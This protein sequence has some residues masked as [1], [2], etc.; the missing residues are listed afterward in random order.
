MVDG[1]TS[2]TVQIGDAVIDE[3]LLGVS[4][5]RDDQNRGSAK[6]IVDPGRCSLS[7]VDW[8]A[9]IQIRV[10]GEPIFTGVVDNV[11][12]GSSVTIRAVDRS[13]ELS[14]LQMGGLAT[15]RLPVPEVIWSLM[16][17]GGVPEDRMMIEGVDGPTEPFTVTTPLLGV[18]LTGARQ[19][20]NVTVV[21][22]GRVRD[23]ARRL[24][25]SESPPDLIE[26]FESA[27]AWALVTC[28]EA[29]VLD[30]ETTAL[31]RVDVALGWMMLV[32]HYSSPRILDRPLRPYYRAATLARPHRADVVMV[33]GT[34]TGRA[35]LRAPRDW[36]VERDLSVDQH[37]DLTIPSFPS[38]LPDEI[39]EA[40]LSWQRAVQHTDQIGT[41]VALWEAIEFYA[42]STKV[43]ALFDKAE[44]RSIRD[45]L[46][47][48][49]GEQAKRL[50]DAINNLNNAPLMVRLEAALV[51][52]RMPFVSADLE[53]LKRLRAIRNNFAHGRLRMAP[54]R[55]D[56]RQGVAL[57]G[58]MLAHRV[59][60]LALEEESQAIAE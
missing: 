56:V 46:P 31:R 43:D 14:E 60:K 7:G 40:V 30:A 48:L 44:L 36:A 38:E 18:R 26:R 8:R 27:S 25:G 50:T 37:A 13:Q 57:V 55:Q 51:A 12:V 59:A 42:S 15:R 34:R 1:L 4:T 17:A 32:G 33:E 2:T 52:D 39:G 45:Q 53:L 11:E 28:D 20:A 3:E 54:A 49:S 58:R 35:W 21:G 41:I 19:W 24:F 47:E 5:T 29:T 10:N 16:R 23:S 22:S 6:V 9:E